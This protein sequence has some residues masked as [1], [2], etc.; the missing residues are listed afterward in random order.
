MKY[1]GVQVLTVA[2]LFFQW[3]LIVKQ[4]VEVQQKAHQTPFA[5]RLD[6]NTL[7]N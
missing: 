7:L 5:S 1:E 2:I 4:S 6:I 3:G